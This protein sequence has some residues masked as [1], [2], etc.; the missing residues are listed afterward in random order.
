MTT[1]MIRLGH[2]SKRAAVQVTAARGFATQRKTKFGPLAPEILDA[3]PYHEETDV[4][5]STDPMAYVRKPVK[6]AHCVDTVK[7]EVSTL[8]SATLGPSGS[9]V[10]GRYGDLGDSAKGIPL[11]YLALLQPAAEGAA[12]LRVMLEKSK[13]KGKGTFLVYGASQ[14]NGFAAAQLASSAGHAVVAVVGGEH[15][16]N[17]ALMEC[18]KGLMNEPGTAVPAEYALSKKNFS[19][20]VAGISSGD[21]GIKTAS[22]D[23]Y[24][25]EFKANFSDYIQV[26]PDTRPAAVS[27]ET[28][29]FKYMEKD[30]E[31]WDINMETFLAQYPPGAPPVD[32]SRLEA[33][34]TTEQYEIFRQKFWKQTSDVISGDDIPFS[35]AHLVKKQTDVPEELDKTKYPTVGADFPYSFSVLNQ[36]FPKGSEHTAGGPILG[37]VICVTPTLKLAA[38]KVAAAK[39]LRAKGEALQFLTRTQRAEYG[40]AASV[41]AQARKAGAPVMVMGGSLPELESVTPTDVDVKEALAAMN[42]DDEGET[43]LNYFVQ[44]YRASD[45]P[46]YA[47][48]AVHRAT[49]VLAGPRQ[50]IVTK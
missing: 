23:K 43:R 1:M 30:R 21:D 5:L 16:G 31:Y 29:E 17:E 49:E 32:P 45:F 35:A 39:T 14:A 13:A 7:G 44:L 50:I 38:E 27:A 20:L 26:Y 3:L 47:D 8:D 36:F 40:A 46:F 6:S 2:L 24:L 12:A 19:N 42:I 11:E 25:E 33:V 10:H 48:Y 4:P 9:V 18:V 34:F 28:T 37:A 41:A 15:S 22:P